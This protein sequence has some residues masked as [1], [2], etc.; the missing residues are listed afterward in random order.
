[1]K[2][3]YQGIFFRVWTIG[4]KSVIMESGYSPGDTGHDE[5]DD[6]VY[7]PWNI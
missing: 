2:K 6:Y 7:S 5:D 3:E 1:M 4:S